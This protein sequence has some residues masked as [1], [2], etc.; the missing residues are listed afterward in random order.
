MRRRAR[1]KIIVIAV[2]H[3]CNNP[4]MLLTILQIFLAINFGGFSRPTPS[5]SP[6]Y[7]VH[8]I[9][10]VI[11]TG[12]KDHTASLEAGDSQNIL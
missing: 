12:Y 6:V 4:D 7:T 2:K 8:A 9:S 10:R 11:S 1:K 3:T 5:F